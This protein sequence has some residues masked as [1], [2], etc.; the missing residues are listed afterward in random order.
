MLYTLSQTFSGSGLESDALTLQLGSVAH[1]PREK[2]QQLRDVIWKVFEQHFATGTENMGLCPACQQSL[3]QPSPNPETAGSQDRK[4]PGFSWPRNEWNT[5]SG[6]SSS[7]ST[8]AA[9]QE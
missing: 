7:A 9:D 8:P 1:M 2:R 5:S 4:P 6:S 3:S